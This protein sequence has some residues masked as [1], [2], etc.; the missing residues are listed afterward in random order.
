M[1]R[2]YRPIYRGDEF[3]YQENYAPMW[4]TK[5]EKSMAYRRKFPLKVTKSIFWPYGE[6]YALPF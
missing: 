4:K 5:L 3:Q 2:N 6:I 1:R